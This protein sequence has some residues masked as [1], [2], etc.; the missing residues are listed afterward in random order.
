MVGGLLV[1]ATVFCVRR[2]KDRGVE[3]DPMG[4]LRRRCFDMKRYCQRQAGKGSCG[5]EA[6]WLL[7]Q[8]IELR[9]GLRMGFK[10]GQITRLAF[11]HFCPS[12]IRRRCMGRTRFRMSLRR[13]YQVS[14]EDELEWNRIG[15]IVSSL[16]KVIP[17]VLGW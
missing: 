17:L 1:S 5:T 16:L 11:N 14:I 7:Q 6:A 10:L 3:H 12:L 13:G 2:L 9:Q 4:W 15:F 8:W